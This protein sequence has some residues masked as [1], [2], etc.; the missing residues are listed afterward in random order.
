MTESVIPHLL[1]VGM[2]DPAI[3]N[4]YCY[5]KRTRKPFIEFHLNATR[6]ILRRKDALALVVMEINDRDKTS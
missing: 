4:F 2:D 3:A 6:A 5:L 1:V